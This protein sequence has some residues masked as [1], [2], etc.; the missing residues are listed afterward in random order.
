VTIADWPD[1]RLDQLVK[2]VET[3]TQV[4]AQLAQGQKSITDI[5]DRLSNTQMGL[6]ESQAK[7]T[8]IIEQMEVRLTSTTAAVERLEAIVNHLLKQV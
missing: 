5:I 6:A 2:I 8:Q 4:I 7:L 1:E 3:N